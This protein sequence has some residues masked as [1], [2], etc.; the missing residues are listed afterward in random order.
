MSDVVHLASNVVYWP[1][2]FLELG[3]T[4]AAKM[5]SPGFPDEKSLPGYVT[6]FPVPEFCV[7]QL[8]STD[9]NTSFTPGLRLQV[10]SVV[11][12]LSPRHLSPI[13]FAGSVKP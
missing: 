8:I 6:M 2:E 13:G 7:Q 9:L 4:R 10:S 11:W 5:V 3:W 1:K 12:V